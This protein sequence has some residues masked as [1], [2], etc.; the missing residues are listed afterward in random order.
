MLD[1]IKSK[2]DVLL[3]SLA[4]FVVFFTWVSLDL[5]AD[6]QL[7][8]V[9]L[10]TAFLTAVGMRPRPADQSA[11]TNTGDINVSTGKENKTP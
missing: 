10:F 3:I 9:G 4:F 7:F 11:N 1:L 8:V 6:L 5:R 2:F